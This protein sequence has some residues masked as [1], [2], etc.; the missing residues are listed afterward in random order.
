MREPG[1]SVAEM[2]RRSVLGSMAATAG[3]LVAMGC[4][5]PPI[6]HA[7]TGKGETKMTV[8]CFIRY[9]IDPFQREAFQSMRR[10]GDGSSRDAAVTWWDIFCRWKERTMWGGG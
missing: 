1:Y 7:K 8:T 10:T 3:A 9:Q 5:A 4:D 2:S 6:V